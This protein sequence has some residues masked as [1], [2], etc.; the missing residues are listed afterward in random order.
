M[1]PPS[2]ERPSLRST[3]KAVTKVREALSGSSAESG[4]LAGSPRGGPASSVSE[5]AVSF[6]GA[7]LAG[8]VAP[9]PAGCAAPSG[10]KGRE[11]LLTHEDLVRL[12]WDGRRY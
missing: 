11:G 9:R 5:A 4:V 8:A 10:G 2:L 12:L 7:L 6:G 3:E 1:Q